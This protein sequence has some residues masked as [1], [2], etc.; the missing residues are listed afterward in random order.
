MGRE[1][2][3][4]P[5]DFEWE[6]YSPWKGYIYPHPDGPYTEKEMGAHYEH[7]YELIRYDPP[8]G[9]GYQMWETVTEGSPVTPVFTNAEDLAHWLVFDPRETEQAYRQ[10]L[11]NI[12]RQ[13]KSLDNSP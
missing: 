2:K 11:Q 6:R 3:R 5:L 7:W 1:L 4:V 13:S 8:T 9:K 10:A 12:E